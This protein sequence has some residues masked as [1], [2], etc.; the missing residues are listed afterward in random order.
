MSRIYRPPQRRQRYYH[1][2]SIKQEPKEKP[3]EE[4]KLE[5][6][7]YNDLFPSLGNNVKNTTVT[8]STNYKDALLKNQVK[9]N[10]KDNKTEVKN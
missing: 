3:K 5:T 9:N 6:H 8:P 1:D 4:Q 2:D 10:I 7:S